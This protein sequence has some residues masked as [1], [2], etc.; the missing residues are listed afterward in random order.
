MT[1]QRQCN[2]GQWPEAKV[3]APDVNSIDNNQPREKATVGPQPRSILT[4]QDLCLTSACTWAANQV[5]YW[6]YLSPRR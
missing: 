5:V 6:L 3:S 4:I 1:N 2:H